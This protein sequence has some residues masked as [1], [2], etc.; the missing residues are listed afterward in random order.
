MKQG[1]DDHHY[2]LSNILFLEDLSQLNKVQKRNKLCKDQK[3][4]I[5]FSLFAENM[6]SYIE[7]LS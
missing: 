5:K 2:L 7:S 6:I 3:K 4:G 1:K